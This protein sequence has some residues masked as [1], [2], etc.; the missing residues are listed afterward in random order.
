MQ[1][2][3][4]SDADFQEFVTKGAELSYL[5]LNTKITSEAIVS[6]DSVYF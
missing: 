6:I 5:L 1:I 3:G 2:K 4:I